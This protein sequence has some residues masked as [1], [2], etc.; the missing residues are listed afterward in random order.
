MKDL[1]DPVCWIWVMLVVL[2][3]WLYWK[4]HH[5]RVATGLGF[6]AVCWSAI[7]WWQIPA[8]LLASLETPFL[9]Q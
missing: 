5:R 2:A 4:G 8:R 3:S 7:V 9:A 6:V 1:L